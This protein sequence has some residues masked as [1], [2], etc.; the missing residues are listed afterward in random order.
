MAA[1]IRDIP[2]VQTVEP[3]IIGQVMLGAARGESLEEIRRRYRE[4]LLQYHPDRVQH[5]GREFQEMAE[6]KTKEITEAFRKISRE[7][8]KG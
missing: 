7:R 6:Q 5:L 3:F 2:G 4:K 1:V 8:A